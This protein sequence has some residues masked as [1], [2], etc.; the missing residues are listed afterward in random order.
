MRRSILEILEE[1][2]KKFEDRIIYED[3][4]RKITY[5]Q[6]IEN[7]QKIGTGLAKDV[8][9]INRPVAIYIDRSVTCLESMMGVTYSGNYFIVL[10]IK[11]PKERNNKILNSLPN[12]A[13]IV[14]EKNVQ[15]VKELDFNGD[16]YLYEELIK[17]DVNQ[18]LLDEIRGYRNSKRYC[19]M[20]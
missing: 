5:K 12:P 11:S 13:I 20:S 10:D 4:N 7:C 3:I 18:T 15:K 9:D 14:E 8:K 2:G 6:Y 19:Y 16:I 1:T 17:S